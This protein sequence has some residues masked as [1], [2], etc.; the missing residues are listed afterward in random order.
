MVTVYDIHM[1]IQVHITTILKTETEWMHYCVVNGVFI[2]ELKPM[3]S[4][5]PLD[6][7]MA[8]TLSWTFVGCIIE[9]SRKSHSLYPETLEIF[10]SCKIIY[11]YTILK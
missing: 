5:F 9:A 3:S 7:I 4:E 6:A 8:A 2:N 10:C 1:Y 11:M